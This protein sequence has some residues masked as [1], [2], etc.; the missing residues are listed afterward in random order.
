M[1]IFVRN[2]IANDFFTIVGYSLPEYDLQ[3]ICR[4]IK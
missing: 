1:N 4:I 3:E 2:I